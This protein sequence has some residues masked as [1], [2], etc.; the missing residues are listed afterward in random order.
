MFSE[1]PE[2]CH[3]HNVLYIQILQINSLLFVAMH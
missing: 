1:F 2:E 3:D